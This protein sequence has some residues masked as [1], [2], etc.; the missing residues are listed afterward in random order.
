[1][2]VATVP[3]MPDG[4][5]EPKLC[6]IADLAA[7]P[8]Q[9][10]SGPVRWELHYGRLVSMAPPGDIHGAAEAMVTH[11]LVACGDLKGLGKSRCGEV[12]I[13]LA[14]DPDHVL[15]A[16]AVFV[17]KNRYPI[18]RSSE[19]Y[20]ETIPNLVVE[21]RSKNETIV[22]L[23][24]KSQEYLQAGVEVVWVVDPIQRNVVEYRKDAEPRTFTEDDTLTLEEIIPGFQLS[25]RLALED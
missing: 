1:M 9:L 17:A 16:D 2:S 20:L 24:R 19:G 22:G 11:A 12:G 23:A 13:V 8:S 15:G 5:Y 10:P 3:P 7:M 18:V 6:T 25:V 14:R 4:G 21:V